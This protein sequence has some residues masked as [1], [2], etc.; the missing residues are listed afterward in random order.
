MERRPIIRSAPISG[1]QRLTL[2]R[3][4]EQTTPVA[5]SMYPGCSGEFGATGCAKF[6]NQD[7]FEGSPRRPPFIDAV[8]TGYKP[9]TG[10]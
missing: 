8:A 1:G 5:V 6:S 7:N 9:K 10:K 2:T 3:P 4:L